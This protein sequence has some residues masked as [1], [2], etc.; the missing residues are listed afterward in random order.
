MT[1]PLT[2]EWL[3][4][5]TFRVRVAGLTL[6]FDTFVDRIATAPQVGVNSAEIREA[7]FIL[8][9]HAHLDHILGADTIALNTGAPVMAI[10][11]AASVRGRLARR[12][13]AWWRPSRVAWP[14]RSP[15]VAA[16][17]G[18]TTTLLRAPAAYASSGSMSERTRSTSSSGV[19][20]LASRL[21]FASSMP[22]LMR[23]LSL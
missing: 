11:R 23:R 14:R 19:N 2:L 22:R 12:R 13:S 18:W 5:T 10:V 3:G 17:R 6:F 16:R 9:S 21:T 7:D 20:G 1:L 8:I 15:P 4:V